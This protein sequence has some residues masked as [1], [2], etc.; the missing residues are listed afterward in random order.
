MNVLTRFLRSKSGLVLLSYL[1]FCAAGSAGAAYLFY[2]SSMETFRAFAI[3]VPMAPFSE[4]NRTHSYGL[5]LGLFAV[6]AGF[7]L[8]FLK[9]RFRHLSDRDAAAMELKSEN[10]RIQAA[11]D[12]MGEGL[13]MFDGQK[14]LVVWNDNYAKWYQLPE[15]LLRSVDN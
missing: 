13:C 8:V 14:R 9:F 7:G 15:D 10:K 6:L 11:L 5:G 12:N 3:D 2:Q 1:A 4:V